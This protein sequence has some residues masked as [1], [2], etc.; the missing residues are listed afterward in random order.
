LR[1]AAI[2]GL[3]SGSV[4]AQ[5]ADFDRANRV[6]AIFAEVDRNDTPGCAVAVVQAGESVLA[7]GYGLANLEHRISV[8]PQTVFDA[9]SVSKQFTAAAIARL[10]QRGEISLDTPVRDIIPELPA[11]DPPPTIRQLVHHTSGVRDYLELLELSGKTVRDVH[12]LDELIGLLA[13]QNALNFVPGSR[14]LYSNSGYILLAAIAQRV[15]DQPFGEILESNIFGPL[16]MGST[17]VYD[18]ATKIIPRRATGYSPRDVGFAVDHFFEFAV[19]GDGQVYTTVEDLAKWEQAFHSGG[20]LGAPFMQGLLAAGELEGG[21]VVDYAYGLRLG[22]WRGLRTVRHGGAWGGF[23]SHTLRFPDEALSV[24][25]LCNNGGVRPEELAENV[26]TVYLDDRLAPVPVST[27]RFFPSI[28][29]LEALQGAFRG[30]ESGAIWRLDL[31]R[32]SLV[33]TRLRG[34]GTHL[35]APLAP[36]RFRSESSVPP[37]ELRFEAGQHAERQIRITGIDT[38][39]TF[40]ELPSFSVEGWE[41]DEYAGSYRSAELGVTYLLEP[42]SQGTL[43]LGRGRS[44]RVLWPAARDTFGDGHWQV[45][46]SRAPDGF[47]KGLTV[48]TERVLGIPFRRLAD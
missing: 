4:A 7:R 12:T 29:A 45:E 3:V 46:F 20:P 40:V 33:A 11:Y 10:A 24:V 34:G 30:P 35:L 2:I 1:L 5:A 18:D 25:C 47:I 48:S 22:E 42:T 14:H 23:R 41:W 19:P 39:E 6:E 15:T 32:G 44:A 36:G 9:S 26:A 13:R 38:A 8:T 16:G 43:V 21:A 27:P 28:V 31:R 17:H 37:V